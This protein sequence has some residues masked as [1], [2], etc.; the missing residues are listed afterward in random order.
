MSFISSF[1]FFIF[2]IFIG[3]SSIIAAAQSFCVTHVRLHTNA[4]THTTS[5]CHIIIAI[6]VSISPF[7]HKHTRV[8]VCGLLGSFA[9]ATALQSLAICLKNLKTEMATVCSLCNVADATAAATCFYF[10]FI[11]G[12]CCC[13]CFC[14]FFLV[15]GFLDTLGSQCCHLLAKIWPIVAPFAVF[16]NAP[17]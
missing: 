10:H 3:A 2:G 5:H 9:V 16:V 11:F 14:F 4:H 1:F 6:A 13:C 12:F 8:N 15:F 7:L 17:A